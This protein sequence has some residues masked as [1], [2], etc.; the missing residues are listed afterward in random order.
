MDFVGFRNTTLAI[1]KAG[2]G[3][4]LKLRNDDVFGIDSFA[5]LVLLYMAAKTYDYPKDENQN[6]SIPARYYD[7]GWKTIAEGLGLLYAAVNKNT[8]DSE[9]AALIK[10]RKATAKNRI[11][12]AWTFLAKKNLLIQLKPPSLGGNAGY[13]LLLGDDEEN[14]EVLESIEEMIV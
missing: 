5:T 11:S 13:V 4:T 12:R 7:Q 6:P 3:G 1:K 14:K 9:E 2:D 10:K 8:T